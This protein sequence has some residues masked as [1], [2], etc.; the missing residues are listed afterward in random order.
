[1]PILVGD[2]NLKGRD[3]FLYTLFV[4]DLFGE[5]LLSHSICKL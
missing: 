1:M 5:L 2:G 3:L 4:I